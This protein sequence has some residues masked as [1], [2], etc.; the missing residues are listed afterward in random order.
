MVEQ[1][2][3]HTQ[4]EL[5]EQKELDNKFISNYN[6]LSGG[7]KRRYNNQYLEIVARV[8]DNYKAYMEQVFI[9]S[10]VLI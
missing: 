9:N 7:G 3:T 4:E 8:K 5:I 6:I 1:E 2:R 10:G